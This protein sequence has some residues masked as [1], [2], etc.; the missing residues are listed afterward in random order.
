MSRLKSFRFAVCAA[1]CM[2]GAN[3]ASAALF[4]RGGGLIYDDAFNITWLADAN[5]V[6]PNPA[7]NP[8][9]QYSSA[10]LSGPTTWFNAHAWVS[11]LSYADT[12]RGVVYDDWRLPS[13]IYQ[14][15]CANGSCSELRSLYLGLLGSAV[16]QGGDNLLATNH[17][18]SYDLFQ[19]IQPASYWSS[20]DPQ[21]N[22][23][24]WYVDM[25]NGGMNTSNKGAASYYVWA[26]RDGDVATP[27]PEPE[28]YAMMGIGLG[29]LRWVGR[30]KKLQAAA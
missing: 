22:N 15:P 7:Y 20:E 13:T 17:N 9:N 30:R 4:D 8:D 3:S 6:Y 5:Y 18:N 26:V 1:L 28:I 2:L 11:N 27:I 10:F 12:V 23:D 25:S 14:Y 21:Q 16:Q 24:A 29:L 19:S